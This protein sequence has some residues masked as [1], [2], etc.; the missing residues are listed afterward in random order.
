VVLRL[1]ISLLFA[2]GSWAPAIACSIAPHYNENEFGGT[3]VALENFSTNASIIF[4][5]RVNKVEKPGKIQFQIIELVKSTNEFSRITVN[6]SDIHGTY[7]FEGVDENAIKNQTQLLEYTSLMRAV[8]EENS[9]IKASGGVLA[10]IF[11]GTDC[12]RKTMTYD[13]QDYLLFLDE[14]HFAMAMFPIQSD[15]FKDLSGTVNVLE[16]SLQGLE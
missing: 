11:H 9:P 5:G 12:E 2:F 14:R 1:F 8:S 16:D 7:H 3:S 6:Y 13:K 4:K 10:R 15:N